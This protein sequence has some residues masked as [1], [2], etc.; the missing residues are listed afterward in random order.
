M[1]LKWL[2]LACALASVSLPCLAYD[3]T[4]FLSGL[5]LPS[6]C[7]V[8]G[9]QTVTLPN[10]S[11][12]SG[13]LGSSGMASNPVAWSIQVTGCSGASYATTYF[14]PGTGVNANGRLR[15]LAAS[16]PAGNVDLQIL[17]HTGSVINLAAAEGSQ[18]VPATALAGGAGDASFLV[19]YYATGAATAGAFISN[20]TFTLTYS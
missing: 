19:R 16:S 9:T 11:T 20:V 7:T 18:G 6:T 10:V 15:N 12:S 2:P 14:E 13:T 1:K 5:V 3:T 4:L 17:T 8:S